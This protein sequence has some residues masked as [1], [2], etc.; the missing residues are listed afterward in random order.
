[1]G[2]ACDAENVPAAPAGRRHSFAEGRKENEKKRKKKKVMTVVKIGEGSV[3]PA[4]T[5]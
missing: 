2:V 5:R 3:R 4:S 1:M